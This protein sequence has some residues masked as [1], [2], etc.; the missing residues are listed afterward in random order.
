MVHRES[1]TSACCVCRSQRL[2]PEC[3]QGEFPHDLCSDLQ[4]AI[5]ASLHCHMAVFDGY[6]GGEG[7]W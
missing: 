6:G 7:V 2:S 5:F 4:V 1:T 3:V